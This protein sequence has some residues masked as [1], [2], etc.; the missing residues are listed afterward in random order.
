M[1]RFVRNR[2]IIIKEDIPVPK[3]EK[4]NEIVK[5]IIV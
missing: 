4:Q 5:Q 2:P 3:E 1:N